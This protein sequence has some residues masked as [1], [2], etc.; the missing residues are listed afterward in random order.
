MGSARQATGQ[1]DRRVLL[2]ALFGLGAV[3]GASF[4]RV[5]TGTSPAVRLAAAGVLA[6]GMAALLARRHLGLSLL[7][8]AGALVVALGILVFPRTTWAGL[9]TDDTIRA[10]LRAMERVG[11]RASAEVAPAPAFGS[12]MT[13][14]MIAVWASAAAAHALAV[15][16]HSV[17]LP[18]LPSAVLLA[19]A[20]VVTDEGPRPG[21]VVAFLIVAFAML[22]GGALVRLRSWG[23]A[24]GG[25]FGTGE[26]ARWARWL[27]L[28]ALGAALVVPGVLPGLEGGAVLRLDRPAARVT[29]S[30]IVDIRPSLLQRPPGDLF[31]VQTDTSAY[32]RLVTLDRFNGRVW[33]SSDVSARDGEVVE[34]PLDVLAGTPSPEGVRIEQTIE[35]GELSSAWLPAAYRPV[36]VAMEGLSARWDPVSDILATDDAPEPDFRYRVTSIV[37]E[38]SPERLDGLDPRDGTEGTR[39][40][41]LPAGTPPRVFAIAADLS[42]GAATPFRKL[43]AIQEHL[44]LFTYDERAPAGHGIDDL[45]FFLEESR[46]GYCEQFAGTMAVLARAL[47]Y[48]ARV[49]VGF[50]P[51]DPDR[52]GR[53]RVTTGDVHAWPEVWFPEYGWM[54]FEPTPTRTNPTADYLTELP[55]GLIPGVGGPGGAGAEGTAG[56]TTASQ[57]E[58]LAGEDTP[59][60]VPLRRR[61]VAAEAD[62]GFPLREVLLTLLA[63]AAAALALTPPAKALARRA[64]LLRA[65]TPRRRAMAAFRVLEAGAADVG[66]ARGP[67]E[68]PW[69]YRVRL[70]RTF[71]LQGDDLDRLTTIAGR[72]MYAP[73]ELPPE[74]AQEA[75]AAARRAL[76]DIRRRSGTA[77]VV[78]GA[79]RPP[80]RPPR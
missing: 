52:T 59:A 47:G 25:R 53:Y 41:A 74:Q 67:G 28:A 7:A 33:T 62:E 61:R 4:G 34:G 45:L 44:R 68:T 36:T 21:Y 23:P 30:P 14:S 48:P 24:L 75:V 2:A 15:R 80:A 3:T 20:G 18:L 50:Q 12:L 5:F 72:A 42:E 55:A 19:F 29:I 32:W 40:T 58:A 6:V 22:F 16:S 46:R 38:P 43:L 70:T 10:I 56:G 17:V 27:G 35:I 39:L 1:T 71:G 78:L 51:G 64:A 37:P 26:G 11:E 79:V 66:L 65:R 60:P 57:R 13:A 31:T 8:S 49:A 77:R 9:P 76:R 73:G 69:E 54:A 63:G